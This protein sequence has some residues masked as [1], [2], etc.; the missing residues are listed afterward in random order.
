[1]VYA[2][3]LL[4]GHLKID[5]DNILQVIGHDIRTSSHSSEPINL[6]HADLPFLIRVVPC[7]QPVGSALLLTIMCSKNQ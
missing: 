5:G 1:M 7:N 4:P 6:L 2:E 3:E